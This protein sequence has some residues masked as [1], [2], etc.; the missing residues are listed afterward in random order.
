MKTNTRFGGMFDSTRGVRTVN[1][2]AS[3]GQ[4]VKRGVGVSGEMLVLD[5][6]VVVKAL[7]KALNVSGNGSLTKVGDVFVSYDSGDRMTVFTNKND[8]QED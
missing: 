6:N 1:E 8:Y 4:F 7:A 2:A 5:D 3:A